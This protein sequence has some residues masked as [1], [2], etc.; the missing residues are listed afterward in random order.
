MQDENII[1]CLV[2]FTKYAGK[3]RMPVSQGMK[4]EFQILENS[5]S[6]RKTTIYGNS[7]VNLEKL[8]PVVALTCE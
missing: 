4:R 5:A 7:P 8:Y 3:F 6:A 2:F 1:C